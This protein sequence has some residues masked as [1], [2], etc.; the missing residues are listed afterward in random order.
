MKISM[1]IVVPLFCGCTAPFVT[2]LVRNPEDRFSYNEAHISVYL[3]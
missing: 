1:S 3:G 2:D